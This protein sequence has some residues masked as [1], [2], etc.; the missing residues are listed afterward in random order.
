MKILNNDIEFITNFTKNG[1]VVSFNTDRLSEF[2]YIVKL[3]APAKVRH[4]FCVGV[5]LMILSILLYLFVALFAILR[6]GFFKELVAKVKLD[7]LYNKVTLFEF[8]ALFAS[9]TMFLFS[10]ISLVLHA[11]GFTIVFFIL[12]F[13]VCAGAV[14][15]FLVDQQIIKLSFKRKVKEE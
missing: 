11:C 6:F 13:L 8:I 10:L 5:V 12:N 2:A 9:G 4:G 15:L 7:V 14:F 3:P 1:N